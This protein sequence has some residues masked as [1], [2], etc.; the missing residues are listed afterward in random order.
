LFDVQIAAGMIGLEYPAGYGNLML[1]LLGERA[2]KG[3]TRTD[4]RMRP[5]EC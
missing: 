1:K 2:Q 5:L 3:E 4:W